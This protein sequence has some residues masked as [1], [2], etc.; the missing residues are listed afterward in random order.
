MNQQQSPLNQLQ[1]IHLPPETSIWPPAWPWWVLAL[2][3]IGGIAYAAYRWHKNR[4]RKQALTLLNAID[5]ESDKQHAIFCMNRLLKQIYINQ[6][7]TGHELSG[8][9][10]LYALDSKTPKPIFLPE[11]E[12]L[13]YAPDKS[14]I[15]MTPEQV[16][17][18][19]R[20]WI[21]SAQC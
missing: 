8:M 17:K 12:E 13:A 19:A 10:W 7:N 16:Q 14:K 18:A 20:K 1:D 9:K 11:L 3:I 5:T 21:R 4:W 6:Y 2:I 15:D